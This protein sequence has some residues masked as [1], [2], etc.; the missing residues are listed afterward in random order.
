[1]LQVRRLAPILLFL[2]LPLAAD[3][4]GEWRS[5]GPDGGSVVAVVSAP[6]DPQTLYASAEGTV[7]RSSDGGATWAYAG[8]LGNDGRVTRLAVDA[9]RPNTIYASTGENLTRSLD[10]GET[11]ILIHPESRIN[12]LAAH[13]RRSGMVFFATETG[14]FRSTNSATDWQVLRGKGLPQSYSATLVV[15]DPFFPSRVFVATQNLKGGN[16]RLFRSS[17]GGATWHPADGGALKGQ[18][19]MALV[20][21]PG[22]AAVLHAT[23]GAS[24]FRSGDGGATWEKRARPVGSGDVLT[25]AAHPIQATTLFLGANTGLYRSTNGGVAWTR[26]LQGLPEA[27]AVRALVLRGSDG[28][29]L[30]GVSTEV[31]RGGVFRSSTD[32]N[33]WAL[34]SAGI[35]ATTVTSIGVG[36]P[37]TLWIVADGVLFRSLDRG[38]TWS[39][40]VPGPPTGAYLTSVVVDPT[41]PATV[42]V[43]L[44]DGGLRRSFDAGATWE[45]A[46]S[47]GFPSY[48]YPMTL[49]IDPQHPSTLYAAGRRIAKSTNRG[50]TWA[51]LETG[52]SSDFYELVL[53]PSSPS[54]LYAMASRSLILKT[55]DGGA[56]WSARLPIPR[57]WNPDALTVDPQLPGAVFLSSTQGI[58]KTTDGGRNWSRFSNSFQTR[59]VFPLEVAPSGRLYAAVWHDGLYSIAPGDAAWSAEGE[60][61]GRYEFTALAFDPNDACRLY[62][63]ARGRSLLAFTRTGT[64]ECPLAL[65]S[66]PPDYSSPAFRARRSTSPPSR[67]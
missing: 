21:V 1:M 30:A 18:R 52:G 40:V 11:W 62:V 37:G 43:V 48:F 29:F 13:P 23:D 42:Y 47:P 67:P 19:I 10:G 66:G 17:D 28:I 2:T 58:Y 6:S 33:A 53:A 51:E 35:H 55:T 49:V 46:A 59:T 16:P 39:R 22:S 26:L 9:T 5:L 56:V 24:L 25:L 38:L 4:P 44:S 20:T 57:S 31:R 45:A 61:P 64:A 34:S 14:L 27:G 32:G 50:T 12:G 60:I 36:E 8:Y 3:T 63:G 15:T 7:H 65:L 54:T 41:A